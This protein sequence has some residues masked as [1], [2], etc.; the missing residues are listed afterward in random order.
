MA[1]PA[2]PSTQLITPITWL[3]LLGSWSI[4][5]L[6]MIFGG[7]WLGDSLNGTTAAVV[8]LAAGPGVGQDSC[9][10]PPTAPALDHVVIVARDLRVAFRRWSEIANPLRFFAV[11]VSLFPLALS[12]SAGRPIA[13]ISSRMC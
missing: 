7:Q 3:R 1:H 11:V 6:F 5:V 8:F 12:P 2:S 4:V 10:A 9:A 13:W